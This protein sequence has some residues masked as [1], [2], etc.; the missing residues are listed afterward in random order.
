MSDQQDALLNKVDFSKSGLV[1]A[2]VQ[3]SETNKV[4][5]LAY[6]NKEALEK[7]VGTGY[8]W[9]YSRSRGK[10]WNKGETSGNKQKVTS[11]AVDCDSD[12]LL[13]Y[14]KPLGPACHTGKETCFF[15]NHAIGIHNVK[16]SEINSENSEDMFYYLEKVIKERLEKRPENSYVVKLN[17]KGENNVLK[18]IGEESAEL[19]MAIKEKNDPE[20]VHEAADLIFHIL[21]SLEW[22]NVSLADVID[23]LKKRHKD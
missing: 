10:L 11:I 14:V 16:K 2:I 21:L 18:K 6:M 9:F 23:E 20:I 7:T 19:I 17:D 13:V 4:L 15:D 22:T 8:T 1:P 5:M 12:T 3:D